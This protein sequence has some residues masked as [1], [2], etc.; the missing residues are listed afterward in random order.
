MIGRALKTDV[1]ERDA[2]A[3]KDL[4][5]SADR[6]ASA[7]SQQVCTDLKKGRRHDSAQWTAVG[8]GLNVRMVGMGLHF[9]PLNTAA[10]TKAYRASEHRLIFLD[11]GGTL[12]PIDLP[13][14]DQRT[15]DIASASAGMSAIM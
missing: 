11:W 2:R 12:I 1:S 8:F 9:Q 3:A 10:V 4:A 6:T 15:D 13:F 14:Y 7:W 5:Y